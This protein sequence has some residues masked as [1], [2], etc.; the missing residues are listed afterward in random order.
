[1]LVRQGVPSL[2]L[3]LSQHIGVGMPGD[4]PAE[5]AAAAAAAASQAG[6]L[7]LLV[8]LLLQ[9]VRQARH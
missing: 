5:A 1:M 4:L 9:L 7:L 8:V 6:V 2:L 3:L